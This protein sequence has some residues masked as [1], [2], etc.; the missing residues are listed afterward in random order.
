M[1]RLFLRLLSEA[2]TL[3]DG[4]G[5][6]LS[7][8]WL[9]KE[10]DGSIRSSGHSDYRGLADIADPNIE[11][12]AD[13]ENLVV[14]VPSHFVLAINCGVPG[15]NSTQMRKALPFAVEEYIASDI[16]LMHIAH[17]PL[18]SGHPV[19]C[20]IIS[21]EIIQNWLDCFESLQIKPGQFIL[22]A[23]LLPT[24][25][26]QTSVLFDEQN[27]NATVV[28]SAGAATVDLSNLAFALNSVKTSHIVTIN[29]PLSE[30][31]R[32]QLVGE[33][34]IEEVVL[35]KG[36]VLNYFAERLN[37]TQTINMLQGDYQPPKATTRGASKWKTVG[38]L[39]ASWATIAFIG[40]IAQGWW[41]S[42]EAD[43]L[44]SESYAFYKAAFPTESQPRSLQQIRRR[45]N[46]KLGQQ[47]GSSGQN[48]FLALT[49]HFANVID[50]DT[51]VSSLSY[52]Q[53]RQELT[54]EVMLN[55]YADLDVIKD[56][57]AR[58]GID[59]EVVSAEQESQGARS[60]LR[61]R[62]AS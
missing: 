53:Q 59:V 12:L 33:P 61:V 47:D 38:A 32:S 8:E 28:S 4:E 30:F 14:F 56:K 62:Y 26:E 10:G 7:F 43:R 20:N 57:L 19:A 52:L 18:K 50:T 54:I 31:E 11:W 42:T 41:A 44:E 46:S 21:K 22:D 1:P 40:I 49:A 3:P 2:T 60:R 5:Y 29:G 51:Q 48:T 34:S 23:T 24:G 16:E 58:A 13:P 25:D 39:A 6:A 9:I 17:G 27:S 37:E 45:I 55:S 36:G 35:S 15:R